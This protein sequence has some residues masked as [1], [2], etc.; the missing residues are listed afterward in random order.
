MNEKQLQELIRL[1]R[2]EQPRE[3]YFDDFLKEFQQRQRAE[4]LKVSA[5][6]LFW[7]RVKTG[8]AELGSMRWAVGAAAA[9]AAVA[10]FVHMSSQAEP[11][12]N[13]AAHASGKAVNNVMT[14]EGGVSASGEVDF[15][16][17]HLAVLNESMVVNTVSSHLLSP[18]DL[19]DSQ[20]I[21]TEQARYF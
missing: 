15:S 16:V 21:S 10:L 4:I 18:V 11:A 17:D 2:Y 3:G 6:E 1:K 12:A 9:Y 20:I 8:F 7:E 14:E 5:R 13:V 19:S